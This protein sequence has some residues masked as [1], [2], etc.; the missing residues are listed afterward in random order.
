MLNAPFIASLKLR[1][2]VFDPE[3]M[4]RQWL[5]YADSEDMH[6][7]DLDPFVLETFIPEIPVAQEATTV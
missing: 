5:K 2:T 3:K 6:R 1:E 4:R 7:W